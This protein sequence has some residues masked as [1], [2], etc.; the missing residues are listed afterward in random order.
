[1]LQKPRMVQIQGVEDEAVV[2]YR[3]LSTTQEMRHDRLSQGVKN[4]ANSSAVQDFTSGQ[5]HVHRSQNTESGCILEK[6]SLSSCFL[7]NVG[8]KRR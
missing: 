4:R 7:C 3:E 6:A 2:S 1:M 8:V 5:S